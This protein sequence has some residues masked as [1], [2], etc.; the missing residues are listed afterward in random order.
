MVT[1]QSTVHGVCGVI[2]SPN[3]PQR[4]SKMMSKLP[5]G[6]EGQLAKGCPSISTADNPPAVALAGAVEDPVAAG[7]GDPA[8]GRLCKP[9]LALAPNAQRLCGG[10]KPQI[11]HNIGLQA[12]ISTRSA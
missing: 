1:K 10:L 6:I 8:V 11:G 9:H 7:R 12:P 3:N 5:Y 2:K 4:W